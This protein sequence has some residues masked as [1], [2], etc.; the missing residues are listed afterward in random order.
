MIYIIGCGGVGSFLA[1][2][3]C[4]LAGR[5]NITL[6]DGDTLEAKNLNR[7]LFDESAVGTN[8]AIALADKYGCKAIDRWYSETITQ[9]SKIDWLIVCVDNHPARLSALVAS[10]LSQ[11]RV[12]SA[13]NEVLSSE[14]FVYLPEWRSTPLDPRTYYPEISTVTD[15][16]PRRAGI[17]CTG[18]AQQANRQLVTANFM[19]AALAAHLYVVWGIEAKKL[20]KEGRSFLPF[21]LVNNFS[22]N[23][24]LRVKD[25]IE[26]KNERTTNETNN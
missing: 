4:L 16:D 25:H 9:H 5:E 1:P 17:G 10:D 14:A 21:K 18:E 11:C 6:V 15:D 24:Y 2:T 13:A 19:A 12:I 20:D 3:L 8:K 7:Q 23:E 26:T 22:R